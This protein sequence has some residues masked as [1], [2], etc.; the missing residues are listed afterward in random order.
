MALVLE[1]AHPLQRNRASDVDVGRGD[2]DPE[3][4]AQRP[5][6][7]QLRL[8]PALRQHVDGVPREVGEAHG[9]LHYPALWRCFRKRNR[10]RKRRRIRKLRL[11]ALL[12]VLG[13]LGPD[14]VH[15][16]AAHRGRG[17]GPAARPVHQQHDRRQN[18]YVYASDGHTVLA[19]LRGSQA[20]VVVPSADISPWIKQAIVAIEDK[21]FYEHR[22]VD[23]RGIG[24]RRSGPT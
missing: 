11:L 10:R 14:G 3:L 5:A 15:L 22:G 19:I 23:L 1:R 21:R 7:L 24:A 8:E 17:A 18:T 16:R 4:H 20:R 2:V 13:V 12:L 9:G 6:E